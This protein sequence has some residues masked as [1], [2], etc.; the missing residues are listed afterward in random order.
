M[1]RFIVFCG[2]KYYPGGGWQDFEGIYDSY[3]EAKKGAD[4]A[5]IDWGGWVHIVDTEK[6]EIVAWADSKPVPYP[7]SE[8]YRWRWREK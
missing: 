4:S 2:W 8:D 3:E 1:K 7:D 6:K 5:E